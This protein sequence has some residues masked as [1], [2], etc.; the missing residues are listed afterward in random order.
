M[1]HVEIVAL[2]LTAGADVGTKDKDDVTALHKAC[3]KG[4][5]DVV[6]QLIMAGADV[7]GRAKGFVA[8][9]HI[10]VGMGHQSIVARL[11]MAGADL[12]L[13]D[14]EQKTALDIA[15]DTKNGALITF[16]TGTGGIRN[17]LISADPAAPAAP[18]VETEVKPD[19]L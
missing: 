1:G 8:P 12:N 2:L 17:P 14:G 6:H 19:S 16:L 4:F 10:A 5:E 7:N 15:V 18:L 11:F 3:A 9:I 13:L